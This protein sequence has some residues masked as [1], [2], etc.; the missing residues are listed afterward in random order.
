MK[1]TWKL[2]PH[3]LA[4]YFEDKQVKASNHKAYCIQ[5]YNLEEGGGDR[6]WR[7]AGF[8]WAVKTHHVDGGVWSVLGICECNPHSSHV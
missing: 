5:H 8:V 7:G 1:H 6:N 4:M 3:A 2:A